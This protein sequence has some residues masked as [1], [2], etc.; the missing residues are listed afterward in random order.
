MLEMVT[1]TVL[2][3]RMQTIP[4][5]RCDPGFVCDLKVENLARYVNPGT[6]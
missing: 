6:G 3:S 4:F 1:E 5:R 2:A